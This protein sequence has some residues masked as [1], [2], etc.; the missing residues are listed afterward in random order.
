MG[1]VLEILAGCTVKRRASAHVDVCVV[2]EVRELL[3]LTGDVAADTGTESLPS[4]SSGAASWR[5]LEPRRP[6]INSFQG[7]QSRRPLNTPEPR[8]HITQLTIHIAETG[9]TFT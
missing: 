7:S 1:F 6:V 8:V 4:L 5:R 9:Y 2:R 3:T